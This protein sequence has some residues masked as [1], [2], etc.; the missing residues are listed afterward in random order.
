MDLIV[1][2]QLVV[3]IKSVERLHPIHSAQVITYLKLSG[4]P[5]ALLLNFNTTA[6]RSGLKKLVHPE[7]YAPR[8]DEPASPHPGP[9]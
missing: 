8:Y 6:L 7:L 9:S 4:F 2:G 3:E 1:N 5:E